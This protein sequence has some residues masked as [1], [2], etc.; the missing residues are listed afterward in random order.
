MAS[1]FQAGPEYLPIH[2][3]DVANELPLGPQAVPITFVR[4]TTGQ[5]ARVEQS[6][7]EPAQFSQADWLCQSSREGI[8]DREI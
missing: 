5:I 1:A 6:N 2:Y 8:I 4:R 7:T 3:V